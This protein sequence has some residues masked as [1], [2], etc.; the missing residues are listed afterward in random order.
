[1][2]LRRC[3]CR[4]SRPVRSNARNPW[5]IAIVGLL[6][7]FVF[8]VLSLA[9]TAR[10]DFS[11]SAFK[12]TRSVSGLFIAASPAHASQLAGLARIAADTNLVRLDSALL[13]V[14][15]ERIKDALWRQLGVNPNTPSRGTI[16]L[17]V[18]PAV[19]LAETVSV[20]SRLSDRGGTYQVDLPDVLPR[21]NY[22][23]AITAV[24]LLE[25]ASRNLHSHS[26]SVPAWLTDGL[27][28]NL[29]AADA[30]ETVLSMPHKVVNG[31]P[32]AQVNASQ[33][34]VDPLAGAR[35]VLRQR[36]PLT[37]EQLS[38]PTAPQLAGEDGGAYCASAQIFVAELLKLKRGAQNLRTTLELL[39]RYYNWQ[40]AFQSAF[41]DDF[42]R[43]LDVEKWWALRLA[44]LAAH[45]R[46]PLWTPRVSRAKLDGILTVPVEVRATSNSL[47]ARADAS[48][49]SVIRNLNA[50]RRNEI[51][52]E[53]ITDLEFAQ[54]RMAPLVARLAAEYR[55]TL[56]RY[57]GDPS[58]FAAVAAS[59]R[60][61]P[62]R[63]QRAG[64][65]RTLKEL[66]AL[67][68]QRRK[69]ES[70]V[71]KHER[72]GRAPMREAE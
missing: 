18:H 51:L 19:S 58:A 34:G 68:A 47:P 17:T 32:L 26:A 60:H 22:V 43:P 62:A 65:A 42:L 44:G 28:E 21:R 71:T 1:M 72:T 10:A 11:E 63:P 53:K 2:N 54:W 25:Y 23:R 24:V 29:L 40:T 64:A 55:R 31:L 46:G 8:C 41:R 66:D 16:Y 45:D 7:I 38:W 57:L 49:Q 59:P 33:R 5:R 39:P 12:T 35:R 61:A 50:A 48:L 4:V 27:A 14:S 67:D 69:L 36:P 56:G 30:P 6:Q 3:C 9:A 37:F 52:R 13:A 70:G 15:A 20:V